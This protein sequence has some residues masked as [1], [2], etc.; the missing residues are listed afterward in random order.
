M[1]TWNWTGRAD[2]A[3]QGHSHLSP[4]SHSASEAT[5]NII[6]CEWAISHRSQRQFSFL[7]FFLVFKVA[8]KNL[9]LG[10]CSL[11]SVKPFSVY[12]AMKSYFFDLLNKTWKMFHFIFWILIAAEL[13]YNVALVSG[14]Q[15]S[16]SILHMHV[17][18]LSLDPLPI[19]VTTERW[20]ELP[21]LCG[22]ISWV[23][24]FIYIAVCTCESQRPNLCLP[25]YALGNRNVLS[26]SV[27]PFPLYSSY[28][29]LLSVCGSSWP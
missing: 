1:M 8:K 9:F 26:T 5:S 20:A 3:K 28:A 23:V 29:Y 27:T 13:L 22:N 18:T 17:F 12:E 2:S 10:S 7:F 6:P 24:Y 14:N 21:V 25:P 16:D 19:Q 4:S 11:P 15:G